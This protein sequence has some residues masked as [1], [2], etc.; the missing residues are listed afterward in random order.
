MAIGQFCVRFDP[1]SDPARRQS[2]CAQP[3][4]KSPCHVAAGAERA[5]LRPGLATLRVAE[6]FA[7]DA[8]I[9]LVGAGEGLAVARHQRIVAHGVLDEAARRAVPG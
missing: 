8:V 9:G 2:P 3:Q 7:G 6:Q 4:E 1:F 5:G